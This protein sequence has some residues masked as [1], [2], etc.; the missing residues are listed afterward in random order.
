LFRNDGKGHFV[1]IGWE[2]GKDFSTPKVARG[3]ALGDIDNDGDLDILLTTN[4][5]PAH[6]YRNDIHIGHKSLRLRLEGKKSNR[7]AIGAIVK[8]HDPSG[9]QTQMVKSGSSYLS[10]TE[11]TLTFGLA[12]NPEATRVVIYWPSGQVDEHKQLKAG[13]SYVI[14]EGEKPKPSRP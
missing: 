2:I 13:Q 9:V 10:S 5:G 11:R 7:D 1:D 14:T 12:Q 8:V 6:L 4:G 3:I